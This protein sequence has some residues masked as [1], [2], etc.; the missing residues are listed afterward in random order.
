MSTFLDRAKVKVIAGKGGDG[1]VAFLREKYRPDGGPAG[2]DGGRGGD[3]I[4]RVDEGLHT[5]MDFRYNRQFKAQN[6]ENGMS[7]SKYGANAEDL[8]VKVPPGTS[9]YDEASG[10]LI[11]DL[12]DH[13]QEVIVAKGGRGG[14]GNIRFATHK[15]PAPSI[16]ENGEPG[17]AL[18]LQLELKVLADVGLIGYPSVGKSTLLSIIS[19]AK[20]KVADYQFTTLVPNL[21]VVKIADGQEFVVADMPGLI[22]GASD[23]VGLGIDFLRHIER[24]KILLHIVD[25]AAV[26]ERDPFEDFSSIMQELANYHPRLLE[27]PM[28]I[29]ANKMDLEQAKE[30]IKV[31]EEKISEYYQ[32][33]NLSIPT[34][35]HISA[36]QAQGIDSLMRA[37]A[38]LVSSSDFIPLEEK[39]FDHKNYTI[40]ETPDFTVHK[41][42]E[43]YWELEG[44]KIVKLYQMTNTAHDESLQRFAR[45]LRSMG[46][47]QALREAGAKDGDTVYLE[48]YQFEFID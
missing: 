46:V 40:D 11:A 36:W 10:R 28:L 41:L 48:D 31:F 14:R 44:E 19:N 43:G 37:T 32:N 35:H 25:M 18:E 8:Y 23:G 34:I 6:G 12:V 17:Q 29:V 2:G 16:A 38:Q 33:L 26:H 3:V 24:T 30:N 47:D 45:Q 1:M 42:E 7:K 5:L 15:N 22:D 4:F 20:P 21:G 9:V 13:G 27:R 39:E